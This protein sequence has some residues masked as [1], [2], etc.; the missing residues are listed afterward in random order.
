MTQEHWT[1]CPGGCGKFLPPGQRCFECAIGA[2][3]KWKLG[4]EGAA[5]E[6]VRAAAAAKKRRA[7]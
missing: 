2:V 7:G 5:L 4:D 3:L 1:L 6:R